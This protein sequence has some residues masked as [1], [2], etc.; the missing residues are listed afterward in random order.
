MKRTGE[1]LVVLV[2]Q[3]LAALLLVSGFDS[4]ALSLGLLFLN[5]VLFV[6]LALEPYWKIGAWLVYLVIAGVSFYVLDLIL[7]NRY[8]AYSGYLAIAALSLGILLVFIAHRMRLKEGEYIPKNAP[9]DGFE[10]EDSGQPL[11]MHSPKP[12]EP[13]EEPK[14]V[15]IKSYIATKDNIIHAEGCELLKDEKDTK[16]IGS[17]RYAASGK[18]KPCE[19]CKP[20]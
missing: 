5:V 4:A 16:V 19:K 6:F 8:L 14:K 17:K 18:F 7:L 1:I 12:E 10:F 13:K 15:E 3:L 9:K 20:F 11:P 2:L